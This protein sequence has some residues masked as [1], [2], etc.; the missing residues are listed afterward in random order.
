MRSDSGYHKCTLHAIGSALAVFGT[1]LGLR[2]MLIYCVVCFR[3]QNSSFL[4]QS[5]KLQSLNILNRRMKSIFILK[6]FS[7][8]FSVSVTLFFVISVNTKIY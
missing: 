3:T 7:W 1:M 8:I 4:L 6:V 5:I 2:Y